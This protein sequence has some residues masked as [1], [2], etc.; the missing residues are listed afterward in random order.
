[1]RIPGTDYAMGTPHAMDITFKFNNETPANS[2]GFLSGSN[3]DRY[4]ASRHM[5]E[6]W[7]NFAKTGKPSAIGVP[8]WPEYNLDDR[9]SLRIDK[10]CEII[11]GRFNDELAMWRSIG[12]L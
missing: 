10:R 7:S 8:E 2:P 4:I 11:C 1:M 12:K 3:P 6:L 9:P 5:A